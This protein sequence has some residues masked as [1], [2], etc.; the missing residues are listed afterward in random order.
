M[1]GRRNGESRD[2]PAGRAYL[3]TRSRWSRC[4]PRGASLLCCYIGTCR[5]ALAQDPGAATS[6]GDLGSLA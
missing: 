1:S 2:G 3:W 5:R 6:T 4:L